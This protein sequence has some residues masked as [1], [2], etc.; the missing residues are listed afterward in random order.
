MALLEEIK[1]LK[2]DGYTVDEIVSK[3]SSPAPYW[4]VKVLYSMV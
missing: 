1:S 4:L 2:A 3:L